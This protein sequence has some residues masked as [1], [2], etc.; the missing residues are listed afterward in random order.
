MAQRGDMGSISE[1]SLKVPLLQPS[2][3]SPKPK[4]GIYQRILAILKSFL[5]L[6]SKKEAAPSA[7]THKKLLNVQRIDPKDCP[8]A[9]KTA[10][11]W[12]T[13]AREKKERAEE[14]AK[15]RF[16]DCAHLSNIIAHRLRTGSF[17][18]AYICRDRHGKEQGLMLIDTHKK[19]DTP[20]PRYQGRF[21]KVGYLVSHP[22]NIRCKENESIS[23]RVEGAGKELVRFAQKRAEELH[24]DGVFLEGVPSA[25]TFYEKIGF[26]EIPTTSIEDGYYTMVKTAEKISDSIPPH[27]FPGAIAA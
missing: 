9:A 10:R 20:D 19:I 23:D 21:V 15:N 16:S 24:F 6:F 2:S 11:V 26:R 14:S 4:G 25:K 3:S 7:A 5:E 17:D 13:L 8:T 27:V 1:I 22:N 12:N 18:E